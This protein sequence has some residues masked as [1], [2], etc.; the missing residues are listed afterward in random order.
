[1]AE[2]EWVYDSHSQAWYYFKSGGYMTANEWIWDKESWF[3][4]KFDGKMAEKEWVYD[5]HS[6]AWYYFKSK[7]LKFS[8]YLDFLSVF[9]YCT[10][11][12]NGSNFCW[13]NGKL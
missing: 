3:Y 13:E 9:I 12:K 6:Q 8:S 10:I 2:K 5:S 1:M 11:N 7:I 4:L